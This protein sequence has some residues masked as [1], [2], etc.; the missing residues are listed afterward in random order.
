MLNHKN[1]V[2]NKDASNPPRPRR[3]FYSFI[4]IPFYREDIVHA[5]VTRLVRNAVMMSARPKSSLDRVE[6]SRASIEIQHRRQTNKV[7]DAVRAA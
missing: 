5:V 3:K 1:S 7:A 4:S 2:A 6:R